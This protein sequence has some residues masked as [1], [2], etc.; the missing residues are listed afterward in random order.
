[1]QVKSEGY[2]EKYQAVVAFPVG[3]DSA[4]MRS[5]VSLRDQSALAVAATA[6]GTRRVLQSDQLLLRQGVGKMAYFPTRLRPAPLKG[7]S[8]AVLDVTPE[9]A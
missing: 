9:A 7:A 5:D 8:N 3:S 2:A 1:L 4:V 6:G